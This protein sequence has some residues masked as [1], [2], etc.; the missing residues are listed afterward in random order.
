[1]PLIDDDA[2]D[3]VDAEIIRTGREVV[4]LFMDSVRTWVD[5]D[6]A[7]ANRCIEHGEELVRKVLSI[8]GMSDS[9]VG[10]PAIATEMITS[11]VKRIAEYSMDIC[12][13]AINAA[14]E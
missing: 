11:S 12:E 1:M 7:N 13:T 10:K 4:M 14:M 5:R 9:L 8:S 3:D 2:T 6:V